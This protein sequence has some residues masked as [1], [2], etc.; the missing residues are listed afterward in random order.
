MTKQTAENANE[1]AWH[2]LDADTA[3]ARLGGA[4]NGLEPAAID[5]RRA[6]YGPNSLPQQQGRGRL[7]RFAAQFNNLLIQILVAAAIITALLGHYIDMSVIL[8][9]VLVNAVFGYIQEGRAE[10]AL[11]AIR[12][13]LSPRARVIR[14]GRRQEVAAE[15]LV[16]GDIVLLEAGDRV[17]ADVRLLQAHNVQIDESVLT[18]ESVPAEKSTAAVEA[19][20]AL[21]DRAGMAFSGTLVTTGQARGLVVATGANTEIGHI[22]SLLQRVDTQTTPLLRQMGTFTRWLSL[23]ILV[24]GLA[25]FLFGWLLRDLNPNDVFMMVVGLS[26]AAIPEGLPAILTVTLAIGV[27]RMAG[28]QAIIR[29]LPAVETLGA[30]STIC[31]DKTGT[32]TRNEMTVSSVITGAGRYDISGSGYDPQGTFSKAEQTVEPVGEPVLIELLRGALYCNDAELHEADGVWQAVGDPMEAALVVAARKAGLEDATARHGLIPFDAAHRYMATLHKDDDDAHYV[33]V[34]GAPE[35]VLAMCN[36]QLTADGSEPL[37]ADWQERIHELAAQGQRVLALARK[38]VDPPPPELAHEH[39]ADDLILVGLLG[40]IDPPREEAITAV[41]E[42]H[43]AGVR[44]KMITGDHAETARAIG[45]QIGLANSDEV[46]TGADIDKLDEDELA[47]V[48]ERVDIFARTNPT[49][50]LRLVTALQRDGAVV[51]MTGDGVNDAPAL[52]R[53]DIGIAMGGKGTE[54]AKEAAEMVLADDNFASIVAAVREGRTVYDNLKKAIGFL[55]PVNGGES[56]SL[57]IAILFGLTLPIAPLQILWVNMVSSVALALV[58]AF[59]PAEPDIMQRPPRASGEALLSRFL[60]WRIVLVSTL[61]SIGIYS[62]FGGAIAVGLDVEVARTLAVNALVAMEVWYLF[63]VRYLSS[64]SFT[65]EGVQ[66]TRPVLISLA[67]VIGLQLL[68]IYAP[69]MNA[70]FDS[71][72]LPLLSLAWVVAAG[73]VLFLVLEIEKWLLRLWF[74]AP[75]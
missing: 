75:E 43:S 41:G 4:A 40:L 18:G 46:L 22:S 19:D 24:V 67:L 45:A 72:P 44:V 34:K 9:V 2:T 1:A 39:V 62:L 10:Q 15:A 71:R 25:T 70:L 64:P 54:A 31:S 74:P 26:V 3:L 6:E 57:I 51:A 33:V 58:L 12:A 48:V 59:E 49:H 35:Q 50:K 11:N 68:F 73:L 27:Q 56:L 30:V 60:V 28:R 66:G 36:R 5:Q 23:A 14:A 42:C 65:Y 17:P 29:R 47:G 53:A 69:F 63:S 21:G 37:A 61:F 8:A 13:M 16:P 55:L 38:P 52:K 20:A 32:L 7:Q